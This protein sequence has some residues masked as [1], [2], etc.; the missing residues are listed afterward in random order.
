MSRETGYSYDSSGELTSVTDPMSR[1]TSFTYDS[2]HDLLTITKPN[3]ESG[4]ADAGTKTTNVYNSN[5]QVT[6]QTDPMGRVTTW[7]YGTGSNGLPQTI[8]TDPDG[9][10]T[11][12]SFD[13]N[14]ELASM[15]DAYGT[16]SAATWTYT[17]D[18]VTLAQASVTDPNDNTATET[19]DSNGNL[20][21]RTNALG[22]TW[23]YAYNGFDEQTCAASPEAASPCSALSPP[24]AITAETSTIT[25]PSSAPPPHVTYSEYDTNGN[26]IWQSTGA[27][28]P[29]SGTASYSRTTYELYNGESVTLSGTEDSCDTEAPSGS[30]PCATID[31][32]G[33][34]TELSYDS[35]GD[36]TSSST[37]D[38]DATSP[39][40]TISTF[41]GGTVGR[42]VGTDVG[43]LPNNVT[44]E[45]IA[46]TTYAY[47]ADGPNSVIRR[48]NLSTGA[49]E[50]IA[51]HY[52]WGN[53]GAGGP[54]TDAAL[55]GP[56]E[57]VADGAGDVVIADGNNSVVDFI[58]ATSGTYFG[59]AMSA[60]HLYR[61]AG[62][63][64]A[65]YSG[66]G[67]VATSAELD[68]P[69]SVAIDG[70][71]GIAI[72]EWG[73]NVIRYL[74][75]TSGSHFGQ[76]MTANRIY[77]IV[78]DTI[79]GYSG[80]GSAATGAEL[81]GPQA[82][83]L[84]SSGNIAIADTDNNA[85]RF[86]PAASGTY[87]GQTMTADDIYTIAGD[88]TAGYSGNGRAATAAELNG[89]ECV[90]FDTAGD[91]AIA[92]TNN[93]FVRLVPVSSGTF[94]G[95]SMTAY[96]IYSV[97]G[98]DSGWDTSNGVAATSA[99]LP[100]PYGVAVDAAGDLVIAWSEGIRVVAAHSGTIA[101][102]PV[103]ADDI[104]TVAG[105]PYAKYSGDGGPADKSELSSPQ[106]VRV[107]AA[108]DVVIS[109][110]WN[111]TI[112]F[113]PAVSGTYFGQ[114]MTAGDIYTIAGSG[115]T[116]GYGGDG[117]PATNA[118][119]NQPNGAEIGPSG[120]LAIAD[121]NNNLVRFV[122]ATSGTYFG[123]SM[124][125]DD[126]YTV[127]G[128]RTAGY[129]GDG[130]AATSAELNF[131]TSV[132]VDASGGIVI[133]DWGNDVI[134]YLAASS[135]THFG[136]SM[137][138]GDIYTIA[139]NGTQGYSGDGGVAT[140]GEL[141]GPQNVALDSAGDLIVT[142]AGNSAVRFVPAVSGSYY[143]QSM[144]ADHIYTVASDLSYGIQDATA[145]LAGDLYMASAEMVRFMP[146]S[147]GTYYGQSMTAD[148]I[149]T[150]AGQTWDSGYSGDGGP[151]TGAQLNWP[152][153]VA[154]DPAGGFYIADAGN[155]MVRHVTVSNGLATTTHTYDADGEL[156]S[157]VSPDGNLL[158]ANAAN[159]TTTDASDADGEV[160]SVTSGGATGHTVTAR[161]TSYTYDP[162]G[163][164]TE[165]TTGSDSV[166]TTYDADD[167]PVVVTDADGNATLTC[168]DGDGDVTETVPPVGVAAESLS[169]ASC[170]VS[171]L[172]PSGYENGSGVEYS[173]VSLASDATRTTYSALGNELTV[174][175]PAPAGQ[176]S[177]QT[178]TYSYDAG[179]RLTAVSSP[180]ASDA[181]GAPDQLTTYSYDAA[182]ELTSTT[183]GSGTSAASTTSYCYDPDGDKTASVPGNGNTGGVASCSSS[184]PWQTTSNY[185][186]GY[187]YDSLGELVSET[188]PATASAP[189][190]ATT[191]Y[192][193]DPAGN[194]LASEDPNGVTTTDTYTPSGELATVSYSGSVTG[195]VA[196]TYD[197]DGNE[198]AMTDDSGTSSFAYDPFSELVQA[199]DGNGRTVSYGY[200]DLGEETSVTYPLGSGAAW[201]SSDAVGYGYDAAGNMTSVSDFNATATTITD[202]ADALPNSMSLGGSGATL[203]T[204]YD[205]TNAPSNIG[206]TKSSSTLLGFSY[207]RSPSGAV[208]TETDTPSSSLSPAG[209]A[210]D[211]LSR[212]TQMTPGTSS[213]LNYSYDASS[214]LETLPTGATTSYND[215][216]ELTTS[217]LSSTTTTYSYDA[218][219]QLA[220]ATGSTSTAA[221]AAWNGAGEL[222]S[223]SDA[224]ADTSSATY[225][226]DGLRTS[227]T[228]TPTGGSESTQ[229]F[230]WDPTSSVP[231]LLM[232]S[233]NAYVYG[234][235]GTPIEQVNLSTGTVTYLISD[236]LGSVRGVLSSS[237][238]LTA[239]TSYDA[240]GNPETTGGLSAYTPFGFAGGYT[241][242]TGLVYLIGRYYDPQTGQFLSVDPD[243]DETMQPYAYASDDP[244]NSS[245]PSGLYRS[246]KKFV[247][248]DGYEVYRPFYSDVE[249]KLNLKVSLTAAWNEPN[250]GEQNNFDS[251]ENVAIL[252][253]NAWKGENY[254]QETWPFN[255]TN[256]KD[257]ICNVV[258][259]LKS[260][261]NSAGVEDADRIGA[262]R[263]TGDQNI[264]W[265]S[266]RTWDHT[267]NLVAEVGHVYEEFEI[268][269]LLLG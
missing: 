222:T 118:E 6:S 125:A 117:D 102:L 159:Y 134:R 177:T 228:T 97:A 90:A 33:V 49:E 207:S 183:T 128:N 162:D 173:P 267:L 220:A 84:D 26:E 246:N 204:S 83:A 165:V 259:W 4:G 179:G 48:L 66:D 13:T 232:D 12:Y 20:L 193:Y 133:A 211:P 107:D 247:C 82:V 23:S 236:A 85:V 215:A 8:V 34:V 28:E 226:G 161:V 200:N 67:G 199:T 53:G 19:Y 160:T 147:S 89:P 253:F 167:E 187:E 91:L 16:A 44:T 98:T 196:Y 234:P 252:A 171:S 65:G 3:G 237:G 145:D 114:V 219:G 260:T 52:S 59:Q 1:V 188:R 261:I 27:Y 81:S 235:S 172:Y 251:I 212:V 15:T 231:R 105:T 111:D 180:P 209:Y 18:P 210:Y 108:G 178:T 255:T 56:A 130:G 129:S 256:R 227:A 25:P 223:Y 36:L 218:D 5:G 103:T 206:L 73:N 70:S 46:G 181:T 22:E 262:I 78:G 142:D 265:L 184:S 94:Y 151:A 47:V 76:T 61:I 69:A 40:G 64:T 68:W 17:Y 240:Y 258:V 43:Q 158:G 121:S 136:R 263:S 152:Q 156:L 170:A 140:S 24:A 109:E 30:L 186:T 112:R 88:G 201:A 37:P 208:A 74:A 149:Y 32:D 124:T 31:P 249:K 239:S 229:N 157:T 202:T 143:G 127:A 154:P 54:A 189:S 153:S 137:T 75:A 194:V 166:T 141:S 63:G 213:A 21:S 198:V 123:Q 11:L 174:T 72:A 119:L 190:G 214:N 96:D 35:D 57:A 126:I 197:P 168:Y 9:N 268:A 139:G 86:V 106:E 45:T 243:V 77:T 2:A 14:G 131:P 264:S 192:A 135:G 203:S 182:N 155:S 150:V 191:T 104:Y 169:A 116:A 254:I 95:Q 87:F 115:M 38:G 164:R 120:E 163:N 266:A 148:D 60:G 257:Y 92:D 238:S 224:A 241:D 71:G 205:A 225:D 146:V 216:G 55:A 110:V 245:D 122:P 10:E 50:L 79:A 250:G 175:S 185:E 244:V 51:G 100:N 58:P 132:A 144:T 80:D 195:P 93:G 101:G 29:G 41:A 138:A 230:V 7:S 113:V 217:T 242:P 99:W 248:A 176:S 39:A 269:E 221:S 62:N 42:V 233:T